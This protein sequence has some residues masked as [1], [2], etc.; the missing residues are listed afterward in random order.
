M[1]SRDA[2][3]E[4][5]FLAAALTLILVGLMLTCAMLTGCAHSAPP[6]IV[7]QDV[8][9]VPTEVLVDVPGDPV[10]PPIPEPPE[11]I[12]TSDYVP[13]SPEAM[14][15]ALATDLAAVTAW[16]VAMWHMLRVYW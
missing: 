10:R 11:L 9:G 16:A 12:T 5:L 7:V 6:E 8:P 2:D 14:I 3:R 13:D 4:R 1:L 15:E